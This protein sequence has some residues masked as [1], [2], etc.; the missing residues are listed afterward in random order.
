MKLHLINTVISFGV[1]AIVGLTLADSTTL[2]T[3]LTILQITSITISIALTVFLVKLILGIKDTTAN[4]VQSVSDTV[5]YPYRA[6]KSGVTGA[7]SRT[8]S[9]AKSAAAWTRNKLTFKRKDREDVQ[10]E[11]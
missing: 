3:I 10:D 7:Y 6:T 8:V 11:V 9:G 1:G 4:A 2:E 5:T